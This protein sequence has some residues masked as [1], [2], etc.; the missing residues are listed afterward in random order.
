[1]AKPK[2]EPKTDEPKAPETEPTTSDLLNLPEVIVQDLT[3]A[4]QTKTVPDA[5]PPNVDVIV[6]DPSQFQEVLIGS[7]VA[8]PLP[9]TFTRID[10]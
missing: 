5:P 9:L 4:P 2:T 10:S 8:E 3:T 1:M 6:L 7:T